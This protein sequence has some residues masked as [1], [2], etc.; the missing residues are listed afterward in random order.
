MRLPE[1]RR[2]R[3]A[4]AAIVAVAVAGLLLPAWVAGPVAARRPRCA[5]PPVQ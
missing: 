1:T 5:N 3:R 4:T 2:A